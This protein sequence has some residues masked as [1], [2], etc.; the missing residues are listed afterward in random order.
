MGQV[1]A[2]ASWL[3]DAKV[4]RRQAQCHHGFEVQACRWRRRKR[5]SSAFNR[6]LQLISRDEGGVK[7]ADLW[8]EIKEVLPSLPPYLDD[9]HDIREVGNFAAHPN[10]DTNTGEV[11]DVE[12]GEAEWL[13][14]ILDK[15]LDFYFVCHSLKVW[16]QSETDCGIQH[17]RRTS[18]TSGSIS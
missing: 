8:Q 15:L 1:H 10:K 13:L 14:D 5:L 2:R 11:I 16:R 18:E 3:V 9:L 17:A 7:K 4:K 12:D 6:L